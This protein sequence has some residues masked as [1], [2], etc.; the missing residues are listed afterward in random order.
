VI[1]RPDGVVAWRATTTDDPAAD[2]DR[3]LRRLLFR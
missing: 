1:V 2:L 3:V